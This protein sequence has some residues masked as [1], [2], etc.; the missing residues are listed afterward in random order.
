MGMLYYTTFSVLIARRLALQPPSPLLLSSPS[1][2]IPSLLF[3]LGEVGNA[4]HHRI[5]SNLPRSSSSSSS[6][7]SALPNS[8]TIPQGGLFS[9][10]SCPHYAF[11]MLSWFSF[12][13]LFPSI[14]TALFASV[15]IFAMNSQ[16]REKH[17]YY[18]K[19]FDGKEG[20]PSYP[21]DRKILI[22]FLY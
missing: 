4:F 21:S 18:I 11:E 19:R 3:V 6:S 7:P 22:P 12:F 17:T 13:L 14:P 16:A 20:R 5:L 10:V 15:G 8:Y 2:L 1:L 9:L